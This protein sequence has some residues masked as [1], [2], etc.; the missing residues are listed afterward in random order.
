MT[1]AACR[2]GADLPDGWARVMRRAGRWTYIAPDGKEFTSQSHVVPYDEELRMAGA[3]AGMNGA[4]GKGTEGKG[5][6][7]GKSTAGKKEAGGGKKRKRDEMVMD[8]DEDTVVTARAIMPKHGGAFG[9]EMRTFEH[10][11]LY[12]ERFE[13]V[14]GW[15]IDE[16]VIAGDDQTRNNKFLAR[17]TDI[18]HQSQYIHLGKE[19]I[20]EKRDLIVRLPQ[21][22]FLDKSPGGGLCVL[23]HETIDY[24]RTKGYSADGLERTMFKQVS[25]VDFKHMR[26]FE[27]I[28]ARLVAADLIVYPAIYFSPDMVK[29]LTK[30]QYHRYQN[31][32]KSHGETLP[33]LFGAHLAQDDAFLQMLCISL[34][35]SFAASALSRSLCFPSPPA[36]D[37]AVTLSLS[38][39]PL[40]SCHRP[41]CFGVCTFLQPPNPNSLNPKPHPTRRDGS[42]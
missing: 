28:H 8:D 16:G 18:I 21:S 40:P 20:G 23:L 12:E 26:L 22:I 34:S 10:K 41:V 36:T 33:D 38:L 25:D 15:L 24:M 13:S 7:G 11:W 31:I 39:S 6:S 2:K 37:L 9:K 29:T 27:S 5:E 17:V 19:A 3:I 35:L 30:G 4:E 1:A 42:T 14:R 32:A